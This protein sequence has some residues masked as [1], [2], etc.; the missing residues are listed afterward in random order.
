[1][2]KH[3]GAQ[4]GVLAILHTWGQ[5]LTEHTHLHCV[6]PGGGVAPGHSKWIKSKKGFSLP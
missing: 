5:K 4:I 1:M 3:L 6:V 2:Q